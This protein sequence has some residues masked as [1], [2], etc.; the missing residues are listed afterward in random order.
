FGIGRAEQ[1][2]AGPANQSALRGIGVLIVDDNATNRRI[3]EEVVTQW[4]MRAA[5][6]ENA[7]DALTLMKRERTRGKGFLLIL[8]DAQMPVVDGF[9]LAKAIQQ[10]VSWAGAAFMMLSSTALPED[11]KRVL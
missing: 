6:A 8:L 4:G 2:P 10:D 1:I 9:A 5:V 3:L 7:A 11:A